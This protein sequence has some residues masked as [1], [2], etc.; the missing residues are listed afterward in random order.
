MLFSF[1]GEYSAEHLTAMRANPDTNRRQATA[2]AL[3][4]GGC[5]LIEWY[6]R[7]AN[8]PGVLVIFD[9]P[10]GA[11]AAAVCSVAVS[12]GIQNPKIE[13]LFTQ[14]D[15]KGAREKAKTIAAAFRPPGQ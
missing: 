4:A 2:Q 9:A 7:I 11:T 14:D 15:I 3:E 12:S 13:R 8:G 10:D 1:S 5:K 6:G